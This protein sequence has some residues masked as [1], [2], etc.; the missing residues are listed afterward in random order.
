MEP[1]ISP[2]KSS[3][4][5]Q[6]TS[7][8]KSSSSVQSDLGNTSMEVCTSRSSECTSKDSVGIARF[9]TPMKRKHT[10][11]VDSFFCRDQSGTNDKLFTGEDNQFESTVC[12][13]CGDNILRLLIEEH[14]DYHIAMTLLTPSHSNT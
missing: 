12:S 3:S 14:M 7:P 2:T 4:D 6:S 11:E 8:T 5:V 10:Q 1:T 9:F 13:V